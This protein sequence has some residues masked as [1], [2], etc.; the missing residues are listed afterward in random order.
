MVKSKQTK[1]LIYCSILFGLEVIILALTYF[2][3]LL[4]YELNWL[5]YSWYFISWWSVQTDL[6]ILLFAL[7]GLIYFNN[8]RNCH[9]ITN[10]FFVLYIVFAAVLTFLFFTIGSVVGF[11]TGQKFTASWSNKT[12][13]WLSTV[14]QH[15]LC[16]VIFIIYFCFIFDKKL[17][18]HKYFYVRKLY[19]FYFHPFVYTI[20]IALRQIILLLIPVDEKLWNYSAPAQ[21]YY[22]PYFFQD[23]REPEYYILYL[24]VLSLIIFLLVSMV[25]SLNNILVNRQKIKENQEKM[26]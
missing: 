22:T 1:N 25:V 2:Y 14:V 23:F 3:N 20:F 24:I 12:I 15:W 9:F 11:I 16:P 4:R 19:K 26:N 8:Q 17:I 6:L 5:S 13:Y 18:N 21:N 7:G 10:Q